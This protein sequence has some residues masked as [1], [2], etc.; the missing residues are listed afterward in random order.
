MMAFA[1]AAMTL[2]FGCQKDSGE[3]IPVGEPTYKLEFIEV[4]SPGDIPVEYRS[5]GPQFV[6]F[7]GTNTVAHILINV[8]P[9]FAFQ[10]A[11]TDSV[12]YNRLSPEITA[13]I[14]DDTGKRQW[15]CLYDATYHMAAPL[16]DVYF[17][18]IYRKFSYAQK[19]VRI[20]SGPSWGANI[21]YLEFNTGTNYEEKFDPACQKVKRNYEYRQNVRFSNDSLSTVI[22]TL[23]GNRECLNIYR[24]RHRW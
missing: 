5:G 24:L 3:N 6:E 9:Q 17:D 16:M 2:P 4:E 7:E 8:F 11:Y 21:A 22:D 13:E 1:V 18:K 12:V 23:T 19:I 20:P 14:P 15:N 10:P